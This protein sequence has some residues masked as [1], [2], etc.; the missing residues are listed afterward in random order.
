MR[1]PV[2]NDRL[3]LEQYRALGTVEELKA[4]LASPYPPDNE[5]A[6]LPFEDCV[7]P[8]E[9]NANLCWDDRETCGLLEDSDA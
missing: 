5:Y 7:D 2:N 1:L 9:P 4:R 6:P 8:T 3:E